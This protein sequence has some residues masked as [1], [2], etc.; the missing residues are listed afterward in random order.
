LAQQAAVAAAAAVALISIVSPRTR[1]QL[2]RIPAIVLLAATVSLAAHLLRDDL[3]YRH[4]R[5]YSAQDLSWYLK[6]AN[7]LGADRGRNKLGKVR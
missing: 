2:E 7:L 4:V 5:L 3:A 6:L 1:Q